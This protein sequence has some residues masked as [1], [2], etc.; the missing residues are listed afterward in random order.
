MNNKKHRHISTSQFIFLGFLFTIIMGGLILMLPF[1]S[2]EGKSTSFIDAMFTATSATCVTGLVVHD[3]AT[4]WSEFGQAVILFLIQIGG[5]GV[6][7][8]AV[9]L[10]MMSGRKISLRQRTLMQE[11]ISAPKMGGIVRL[12]G[13]I[14]KAIITIEVLGAV[15]MFPVFYKEFGLLRGIWYSIFHSISAFC[16]AGFDLMGVKE[17]YSSLTTLSGSVTINIVIMILIVVGGLG[18]ITWEDIKEYKFHFRKYRMQS[19]VILSVTVLLIIVPTIYFYFCEFRLGK[20][21][22]MSTSNK[23]MAS[24]F[25]AITP[26]TAGFNT[27]DF[28]ELTGAGQ[29]VMMMLM[30][31]G[32]APGSTAGGMKVTTIAVLFATAFAVF[33][34]KR[35]AH[36]F[37]R[38]IAM[39]IIARAATILLMYAFLFVLSAIA[40]STIEGLPITDVM[41]ET[42]SAV[43]T[44]GLSL[45]LT[46]ALGVASKIILMILMFFGRVGGLTIIFATVSGNHGNLAKLPEEKI[47]VG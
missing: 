16:N 10:T 11:A 4:Y 45:G 5:M 44:V 29:L 9:L 21:N 31:I 17:Q 18:F 47:M 30:L 39:D 12:T 3:T 7:T 28:S 13:F 22:D 25:T 43:G 40:I 24:F 6:I 38:R 14:F 27:V 32:G 1:A 42:A 20:W 46:P 19:K 36:F 35:E 26:R 8:I 37:K 34:K 23:V 33:T 15:F 2:V 41:F